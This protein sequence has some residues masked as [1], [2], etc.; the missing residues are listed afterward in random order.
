MSKKITVGVVGAGRIGKLHVSNLKKMD[1]VRLKTVSD[2][3]A[4]QL[5]DW[6]RESGARKIDK[7]L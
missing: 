4:D 3:F 5:E 6:F 1:N 2:L 7:K